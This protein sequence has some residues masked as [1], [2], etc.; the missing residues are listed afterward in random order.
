MA[1]FTEKLTVTFVMYVTQEAPTQALAESLINTKF[2]Q[3]GYNIWTES[4][5]VDIKKE[6]IKKED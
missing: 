1:K 3:G 6:L 5:S 4:E 2:V